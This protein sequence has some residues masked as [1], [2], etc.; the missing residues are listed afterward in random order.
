MGI[1][2]RGHCRGLEQREHGSEFTGVTQSG[3]PGGRVVGLE[4]GG[5]T[6]EWLGESE[7]HGGKGVPSR[8]WGDG[9]R[10]VGAG[11]MDRQ[12]GPTELPEPT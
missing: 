8:A 3:P 11:T 7:G 6:G 10:V 4:A 1:R 12:E 2:G 5:S 9:G